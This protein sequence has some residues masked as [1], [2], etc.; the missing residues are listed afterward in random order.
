MLCLRLRCYKQI[1]SF[2]EYI[3]KEMLERFLKLEKRIE[4]NKKVLYFGS[5]KL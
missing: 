2:Y 4:R 5:N 1:D 3:Q